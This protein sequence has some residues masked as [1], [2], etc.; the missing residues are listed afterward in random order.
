VLS[1]ADM[2]NSLREHNVRVLDQLLLERYGGK[3]CRGLA[4]E[5]SHRRNLPDVRNLYL[6]C[7]SPISERTV[8]LVKVRCN[9]ENIQ[10]TNMSLH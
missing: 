5:L 8:K 4:V 2:L 6:R 3:V 7:F 9:R 10:G 1:N